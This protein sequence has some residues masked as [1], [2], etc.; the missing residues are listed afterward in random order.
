MRT[1]VVTCPN[2]HD[3][4]ATVIPGAGGP[5]EG[6]FA[7]P[8]AYDPPVCPVCG[9]EPDWQEGPHVWFYT[10]KCN[11]CGMRFDARLEMPRFVTPPSHL[12]VAHGC[13]TPPVETRIGFIGDNNDY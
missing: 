8:D 2:G 6:R 4:T 11:G 10:A 3:Y 7:E 5:P 1:E 12:H 9:D 13:A